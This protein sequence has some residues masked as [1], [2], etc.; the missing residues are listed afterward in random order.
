MKK[1]TKRSAFSLLELLA[2]VVILG[3]IAAVVVP[4]VTT[5]ADTARTKVNAYNIATLN[6]AVERY[7]VD[8]GTWPGDLASLVTDYLPGGVPAHPD[9]TKSYSLNTTTNR[10][11]ES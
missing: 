4:R 5:S 2:V 7:Y 11:Q 1:S 9:P 6:S 8:N 3:I 10:V